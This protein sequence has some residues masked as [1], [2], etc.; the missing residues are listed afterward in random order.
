MLKNMETKIP[1]T[2]QVSVPVPTALQRRMKAYA[3]S[4]GILVKDF[5][6]RAIEELL[7]KLDKLEQKKRWA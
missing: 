1:E 2:I 4:Q 6:C 3:A 7:D 5:V